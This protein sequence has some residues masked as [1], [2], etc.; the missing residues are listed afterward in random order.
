MAPEFTTAQL[1]AALINILVAA[2]FLKWAAGLLGT[3]GG[4]GAALIVA[5][6]GTLLAG[7]VYGL[8]GGGTLGLVLAI[9]TWALVAAV[10]F[11]TN[12]L[13]G[14]LIGVIAWVLW[15]VV[16]W[17]VGLIMDAL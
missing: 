2:L 15:A 4:F 14:A 13:K 17:L 6:I 5:I 7:V 12:L 8:L 11:R 9:V 3:R 10:A 1:V 16:Q